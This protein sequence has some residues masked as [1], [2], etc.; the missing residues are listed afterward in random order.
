MSRFWVLEQQILPWHSHLIVSIYVV[1]GI[2][3]LSLWSRNA[4]QDILQ[5][6]YKYLWGTQVGYKRMAGP[7][8]W[9]KDHFSQNWFYYV[10]PIL[11]PISQF[12]RTIISK[13]TSIYWNNLYHSQFF[14]Y[15]VQYLFWYHN[16]Q[17]MRTTYNFQVTTMVLRI[18]GS[19]QEEIELKSCGSIT[20]H[21]LTKHTPITFRLSLKMSHYFE[22]PNAMQGA[23]EPDYA[24]NNH[25]IHLVQYA[26]WIG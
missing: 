17:E 24:S 2:F 20:R 11:S 21:W 6:P 13:A 4:L 8:E 23:A 5:T 3:F 18:L 19:Q 12:N 9:E 22:L 14:V 15:I 1:W 26:C 16:I 25:T 7:L 10:F